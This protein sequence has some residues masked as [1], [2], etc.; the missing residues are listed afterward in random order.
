MSWFID[1]FR[2]PTPSVP[3]GSTTSNE[4][5]LVGYEFD[6]ELLA[7]LRSFLPVNEEAFAKLT[8]VISA[9]YHL[10]FMCGKGESSTTKVYQVLDKTKG[11]PE[12]KALRLI[13]VER[14]PSKDYK[15]KSLLLESETIGIEWMIFLPKGHPFP[16]A[17]AAIVWNETKG[18]FEILQRQEIVEHLSGRSLLPDRYMLYGTLSPLERDTAPLLLDALLD[19]NTQ[20]KI[21]SY[22]P[23]T[24]ANQ[25][26]FFLGTALKDLQ[27]LDPLGSGSFAQV[28]KTSFTNLH[29]KKEIMALRLVPT[30]S[31]KVPSEARSN[32]Y[33]ISHERFGGEFCAFLPESPYS[34]SSY[35][36]IVWDAKKETFRLM[37]CDEVKKYKDNLAA[38][39]DNRLTL[40]GTLSECHEASEDLSKKI[41]RKERLEDTMICTYAWQ[42]LLGIKDL[43]EGMLHRDLKPANILVTKDGFLKILDFGFSRLGVSEDD[44]AASTIGTPYYMPPEVMFGEKYDQKADLYSLGVI[45]FEL[46]TGE[47]LFPA[48]SYTEL[49]QKLQTAR[50]NSFDPKDDPRLHDRPEALR[51]FI[52]HL[53]HPIA[54][55]RWDLTKILDQDPFLGGSSPPEPVNPPPP[56]LLPQSILPSSFLPRP[57][58][59]LPSLAGRV[60]KLFMIAGAAFVLYQVARRVFIRSTRP[61]FPKGKTQ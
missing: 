35:Y 2:T 43:P 56:S 31:P 55:E 24:R 46:A 22:V 51:N 9:H 14:L 59:D 37:G 54:K 7:Q 30:D 42:L 48:K 23:E 20:L 33:E 44:L 61:H 16:Q 60:F 38:I 21:A 3:I 47:V 40:Y 4:F 13:N 58:F 34:L 5:I 12:T 8:N 10:T 1:Y 18:D 19:Q 50:R 25:F 28:W 45:L 36:A 52:S 57:S 6:C 15:E 39:E 41:S 32:Y 29:G 53:C 17:E 49:Q 11:T 27:I 26:H